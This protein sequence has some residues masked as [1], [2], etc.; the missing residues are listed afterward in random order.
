MVFSQPIRPI[1]RSTLQQ[2]Y[3]EVVT[4][5]PGY[6]RRHD[7]KFGLVLQFCSG[8]SLLV[9][10]LQVQMTESAHMGK[11]HLLKMLLKTVNP[12]RVPIRKLGYYYIDGKAIY[13]TISVKSPMVFL[14][15]AQKDKIDRKV[16]ARLEKTKKWYENRQYRSHKNMQIFS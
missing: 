9:D 11:D 5:H 12:I 4:A 8:Q 3:A 13:S 1:K 14:S 7:K 6:K 2:T 16:L 10:G 15:H